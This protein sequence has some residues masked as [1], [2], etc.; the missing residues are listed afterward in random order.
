M[1]QSENIHTF[2][3]AARI[4][5]VSFIRNTANVHGLPQTGA[6]VGRASVALAYLPNTLYCIRS[7]KK[8]LDC[9]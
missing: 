3:F 8:P 1:Q 5:L 9:K 4:E 2:Y 7:M 6:A